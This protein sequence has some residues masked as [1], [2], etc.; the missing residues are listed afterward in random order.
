LS[1]QPVDLGNE[2][3]FVA[4]DGVRIAYRWWDGP[5]DRPPVVLHH[6]FA[7]DAVVNWVYPGVVAAMVADG[8]RVWAPD[9]RGHGMSERPHD[10]DRYGE[11]A[12][13]R[14]LGELLDVIGVDEVDL[15][16]YSMGAVVSLLVAAQ[17]HRVRR[18]AIGG[19]GCAV[20]ELGGVDTRVLP[21]E[22]VMV[23][24]LSDDPHAVEHPGAAAFRQLADG[25]DADRVALAAQAS[26]RHAEPIAL[27]RITAPTLLVVGDADPMAA[28]PEVLAGAIPDTRLELVGGDHLTAVGDPAFAALIVEHLA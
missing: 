26:R 20:V 10:P 17:D 3:A 22:Q 6:G 15:V 16:G 28:R 12:M 23:A 7:V 1:A 18:L 4:A 25:I 9:A 24:L 14:D 13:A 11:A 19:V 21:P 5:G 8:R 27:G 2:D